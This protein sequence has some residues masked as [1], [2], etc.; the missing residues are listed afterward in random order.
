[1]VGVDPAAVPIIKCGPDQ[2]LLLFALLFALVKFPSSAGLSGG[3]QA[4]VIPRGLKHSIHN[5]GSPLELTSLSSF[6]SVLSSSSTTPTVLLLTML[7]SDSPPPMAKL[8]ISQFE[9]PTSNRTAELDGNWRLG[10][11]CGCRK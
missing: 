10:G 2:C 11:G 8:I 9:R 6:T 5:E 7:A 1:M 4:L 3:R